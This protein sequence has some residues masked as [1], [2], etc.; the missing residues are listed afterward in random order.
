MYLIAALEKSH[1]ANPARPPN[2][3]DIAPYNIINIRKYFGENDHVRYTKYPIDM[4]Y[5]QK[6]IF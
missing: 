1:C 2:Q 3:F 6:Q 4:Y 5:S